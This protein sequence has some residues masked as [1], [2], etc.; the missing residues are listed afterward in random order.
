VSKKVK[1][2][3]T[4]KAPAS[5]NSGAGGKDPITGLYWEFYLD[6][7]RKLVRFDSDKTYSSKELT[8]I[9]KAAG[10]PAPE[11]SQQTEFEFSNNYLV[12][13]SK[14][15]YDAFSTIE[16]FV[17]SGDLKYTKGRFL[18]ATFSSLAEEIIFIENGQVVGRNG[19]INTKPKGA[20][21]S[22]ANSFKEFQA[23]GNSTDFIQQASYDLNAL[24]GKFF[25]GS[26][27]DKQA[28]SNFGNSNFYPEGWWLNPFAPNL[29]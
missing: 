11:G 25:T 27:S 9:Y 28:V 13:T 29:V 23:I 1:R 2:S 26:V 8:D 19:F 7:P 21:L 24:D 3:K 5:S 18:S 10:I 20:K 22:N 14:T 16:R 6:N 17:L 15:D 4:P 12:Q